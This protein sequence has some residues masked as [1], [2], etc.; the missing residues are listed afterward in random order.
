MTPTKRLDSS[1]FDDEVE[2]AIEPLDVLVTPYHC[3]ISIPADPERCALVLAAKNEHPLEMFVVHRSVAY[4]RFRGLKKIYRWRNQVGTYTFI[5]KFDMGDFSDVPLEG[6]RFSF[7]VP[8]KS[9]RLD[10]YR[11]AEHKKRKKA[12]AAKNKGKTKRRPYRLPDPKTLAG[13]R[14]RFGYH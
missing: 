9:H 8:D 7:K 11:S 4:G 14:N 13:V 10:Y 12:S 3:K 1:T 5:C 2:D 6:I